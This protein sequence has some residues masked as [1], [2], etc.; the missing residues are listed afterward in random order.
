[1]AWLH[2]FPLKASPLSLLRFLNAIVHCMSLHNRLKPVPHWYLLHVGIDL[3]FRGQGLGK[4]LISDF[5]RQPADSAKPCYLK[6]LNHENL[7]MYKS[8]GFEVATHTYVP[9][10]GPDVWTMQR[11]TVG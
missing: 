7:S 8:M 5:F 3:T 9:G 6:T 4:L 11:T 10:G 2:E 1:L